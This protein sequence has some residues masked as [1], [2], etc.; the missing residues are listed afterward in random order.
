MAQSST[1]RILFAPLIPT[2]LEVLPL[3][4]SARLTRT[5]F[6]ATVGRPE[7]SGLEP[8][9]NRLAGDENSGM[10]ITFELLRLIDNLRRLRTNKYSSYE[11]GTFC[12]IDKVVKISRLLRSDGPCSSLALL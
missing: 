4:D 3:P 9:G 6:P 7:A 11:K 1:Y 5:P 10:A 12:P 2:P 8:C